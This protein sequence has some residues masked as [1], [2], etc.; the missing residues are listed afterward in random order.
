M[1]DLDCIVG[2]MDAPVRKG[3]RTL[4]EILD[5][6]MKRDRAFG[7]RY[8]VSKEAAQKVGMT[9]TG[10][11]R[12]DVVTRSSLAGGYLAA[13][14]PSCT[15]DVSYSR[16][17][18]RYDGH[19][20]P[21]MKH[22]IVVPA[23]DHMIEVGVAGGVKAKRG[24][25]VRTGRQSTYR[26]K[27]HVVEALHGHGLEVD[28]TFVS[29]RLRT[30]DKKAVKWP[31]TDKARAVQAEMDGI[32]N[33][34]LR[35][36]QVSMPADIEQVSPGIYRC[37]LDVTKPLPKLKPVKGRPM[38]TDAERQANRP[39]HNL[40]VALDL[41]GHRVFNRGDVALEMG[42]RLFGPWQGLSKQSRALIRLN[43]LTC[44]ETDYSSLHAVM[45]YGLEGKRC[46][47]DPYTPSDGRFSRTQGKIAFLVMVNAR[48]R[49]E[50][51][52]AIAWAFGLETKEASRLY[53]DVRRRNYAIKDRFGSDAGIRLMNAD[54]EICIRVLRECI[55]RNIPCLPVHDSFIVPETEISVVNEIKD[56]VLRDWLRTC[57]QPKRASE[58]RPIEV[59]D[60][61][62]LHMVDPVLVSLPAP[63][64]LPACVYSVALTVAEWEASGGASDYQPSHPTPRETRFFA[65]HG[66]YPD[67]D[68]IDPWESVQTAKKV[69]LSRRSLGQ[70]VG[71]D[72]AEE[73][74]SDIKRAERE[75]RY[76][77]R[78][79]AFD[80]NP[81]K[82]AGR[83][84]RR[85]VRPASVQG[86]PAVD[87][88]AA[89]VLA[90]FPGSLV[91]RTVVERA[92]A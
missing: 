14:D 33:P 81:R 22:R 49:Q 72:V 26:L 21:L 37:P 56:R 66:W 8:K 71:H 5:G 18:D 27:Q 82:P 40:F 32:I 59:R 6:R 57:R 52:A 1:D 3:G 87:P 84:A 45:L 16:N 35:S 53:H 86:Q 7:V 48:D 41:A 79:H 73:M 65:V 70:V 39:T 78:S 92:A 80:S 74:F 36:I 28:P 77:I 38:P 90:A 63:V 85:P 75:E 20:H 62:V 67:P 64:P 29:C 69:R 4:R 68:W 91:G 61:P 31:Q 30:T 55:E 2:D 23:V 88:I 51:I 89:A 19:T 76:G 44:T 54:A 46:P 50:A 10:D 60:T 17:W 25:H 34:Y 12:Q 43:G 9:T 15:G 58:S 47:R 13:I 24:D 11:A 42:G 83:P